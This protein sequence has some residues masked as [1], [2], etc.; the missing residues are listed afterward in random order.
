[1]LSPSEQ[2]MWFL[3]QLEPGRSSANLCTGFKIIGHFDHQAW[4]VAVNAVVDRTE[5]L[6]S[7]FVQQSEQEAVRIVNRVGTPSR[8]ILEPLEPLER[9]AK[10]QTWI[11]RV[12]AMAQPCFDLSRAPLFRMH[13]GNIS[14]NEHLLLLVMHHIISDGDVTA[15]IFMQQVLA[16]LSNVA[17][18]QAA[19]PSVVGKDAFGANDLAFWQEYLDDVPQS[20]H[21]PRLALKKANHSACQL[22]LPKEL[23]ARLQTLATST[24]ASLSDLLLAAYGLLLKTHTAQETFLIGWPHPGRSPDNKA[25]GYFGQP[26]PIRF[27]APNGKSFR[28]AIVNTHT[29]FQAAV[30]HADCPFAEIVKKV[31][32]MR[33]SRMPLFQTM[34]DF[35][36][37]LALMQG[38]GL[39]IEAQWWDTQIS[40]YEWAL[41]L[42]QES[43][44]AVFGRIEY[45]AE[46]YDE[47]SMQQ[48]AQR[49]LLLLETMQAHPDQPAYVPLTHD[50][51]A[52][53][54]R[55][56]TGESLPFTEDCAHEWFEQQAAKTP[57]AIALEFRGETQ[58]YDE[59]NQSANRIARYLQ[60]QGVQTGVI[61]GLCLERSILTVNAL[62]AIWKAGGAFLPLDPAYPLE[63]LEFMLSDSQAKLLLTQDEL[64]EK[65]KTPNDCRILL[66]NT[67][68]EQARLEQPNNL[69]VVTDH[70]QLNYVIYT[71]GSTGTPKGIAMV[72]RCLVNIIAWQLHS[73][74]M[75]QE[76]RTLQFASL[77]F[78]ISF[79]EMFTTWCA[80]GTLVLLDETTRRDSVLLL[81]YV[82]EQRINRLFLPFV[83]LQQLALAAQAT[84][85]LPTTLREV[86]TAG[87]QLRST[88][89]LR[90]F[91]DRLPGCTLQNQYGPS[92]A[93]VITSCTLPASTQDW[94]VL[95]AVGKPLSNTRIFLV[96][97][98]LRL[99]PPGAPGEVL[100]GGAGLACGYLNRPEQTAVSF[101]SDPF[102]QHAHEMLYRTGDLARFLPDGSL[103]FIRRV[104]H[105][106]KV[107]GFRIDLGE[108][109]AALGQH[110]LVRE[111][112]VTVRGEA[113]QAQLVAYA[114][115]HSMQQNEAELESAQVADW[116]SLWDST[117][118]SETDSDF[119]LAGWKSSYT[120]LAIAEDDMHEWRDQTVERILALK[121]DRVLE[122]GCGSG[123]LLARVAPHC[124]YY[125]ASDFSAE[126]IERLSERVAANPALAGKVV[127]RQGEALDTDVWPERAFDTIIINSVLQLFPSA[128]YL[129]QVLAKVTLRLKPGGRIFVGDVQNYDLLAAYHAGVQWH[130]YPDATLSEAKKTWQ[131]ALARE[132]QLM[133]SPVFFQGLS[134]RLPQLSHV[135]LNL[136]NGQHANELTK[137]RY[138]V[139]LNVGGEKQLNTQPAITMSYHGPASL[140]HIEF[141][142][143]NNRLQTVQLTNILNLRLQN[144]LYAL[145]CLTDDSIEHEHVSDLMPTPSPQ[146]A[147]PQTFWQLAERL[148]AHCQITWSNDPRYFDVWLG[149][150]PLYQPAYSWAQ[151]TRAL[152]NDPL[153]SVRQRKIT[154]ILF[155]HLK[156]KLPE[157]MVPSHLIPLEVLPTKTNGKIDFLALPAPDLAQSN[158]WEAPNTTTEKSLAQLWEET[159]NVSRAG[160]HDDFF[161]MGGHSLLAVQ[162]LYRIQERFTVHIRLVELFDART[163]NRLAQRI[164]SLQ[165]PNSESI[166]EG[167]L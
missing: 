103:E 66:S 110:P 135:Q 58:T 41:F 3:E 118:Q 38:C 121:P 42:Y 17:T 65:L 61:V 52:Q 155:A 72:H 129:E 108:V 132:D 57:N 157:Y 31:A 78:D 25:I 13:I 128:N 82:T 120:G 113:A 88:P 10:I 92:E 29:S 9:E 151:H 23:V 141:E 74:P 124:S 18:N 71:S 123:L 100:T 53:L 144:D 33:N 84:N 7:Q 146:G 115:V 99:V 49:Y 161:A 67:L 150:D 145:S 160:I 22:S 111:T 164:D 163:I 79:Q 62:L 158:Q 75:G 159:L 56:G 60:K 35:I 91:F 138:D 5:I 107:R 39:T 32:Q 68:I 152:F 95:P 1:M 139:V 27:S 70:D 102:G 117:Y 63:R 165:I 130:R 112:V 96:D 44:G 147:D 64:S 162:L 143:Q 119:N 101:I 166:E 89:A 98:E 8:L 80:G 50:D 43:S 109:E 114:V 133:I 54:V 55:F 142:L 93:H 134:K 122:I 105:Q 69:D 11:A 16:E 94:P 14:P 47:Q 19:P 30:G 76:L 116:L 149:F 6:R 26:L 73:S 86:L 167:I 20:I 87:E 12:P 154:E 140:E 136:K 59:L 90:N 106:V 36:P 45:K 48:V 131:K 156:A 85:T 4:Q 21:L 40:E 83:A 34:F 51:H 97:S 126:I 137:F 46:H 24:G 77:N 104:D 148:G 125:A 153:L 37:A 127:V 81:D 15:E 28:D 2:R